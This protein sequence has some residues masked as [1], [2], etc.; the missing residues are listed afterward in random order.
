M[1]AVKNYFLVIVAIF[2]QFNFCELVQA[3]DKP[4]KP[5]IVFLFSDDQST[6]SVGCYGCLLYTSP[7]PR[8]PY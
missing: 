1:N 7:S 5:N 8:R 4:S 3:Q 6:Y 2:L